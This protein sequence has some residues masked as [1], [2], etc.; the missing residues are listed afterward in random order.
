MFNDQNL[1]RT[2]D[3][4]I[5]AVQGKPGM[6]MFFEFEDPA[7]PATLE[8]R[9]GIAIGWPSG[10]SI[11]GAL[12]HKGGTMGGLSGEVRIRKVFGG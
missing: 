2:I 4:H 12:A 6:E 10:W 1:T 7:G 3:K 5:A 9:L 8:S 11:G